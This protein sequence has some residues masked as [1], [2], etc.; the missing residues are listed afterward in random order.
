M[1]TLSEI[2]IVLIIC[3]AIVI[4]VLIFLSFGFCV[5]DKKH[6]IIITRKK[7][8]F[9][10]LDEGVFYFLPF[11]YKKA[12][13]YWKGKR[14]EMVKC[15]LASFIVSY[16]IYDF[17]KFHNGVG[18]IKKYFEK[19]LLVDYEK[20]KSDF[21]NNGAVLYEIKRINIVE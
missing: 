3:I 8:F 11:I 9:S 2:D 21:F 5:N 14:E 17:K 12:G 16:E 20:Y 4:C 10:E 6:K 1:G 19:N 7:K 13:V 15:K 18:P